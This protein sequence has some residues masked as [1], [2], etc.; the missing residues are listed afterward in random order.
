M[1]SIP[2]LALILFF[3]TGCSLYK[4]EGR[5]QFESQAPG[6]IAGA[7]FVLKSCKKEGVLETWFNGEFPASNYELVMS[8]ADLEIW[9]TIRDDKVEVK[10]LQKIGNSTQSCVYQFASETVW[11]LYKETFISELEN[12]LMTWE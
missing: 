2:A 1:K 9:R 12:N 7:S 3:S 4:S 5:K 11:Q 6:K 8:E 10:A